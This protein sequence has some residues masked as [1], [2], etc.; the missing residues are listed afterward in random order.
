LKVTI[1]AHDNADNPSSGPR[2]WLTRLV[3]DLLKNS[4]EVNVLVYYW[5]EIKKCPLVT[6][7]KQQGVSTD[8]L[9]Y[10]EF[11]FIEDQVKWTLKC[12]NRF[13]P[14][15]FIPNHPL[16]ALYSVKWCNEVRI[17]SIAVLHSNDKYYRYVL[18]MFLSNHPEFT[19]SAVVCVSDFLKDM[20][21]KYGVKDFR[22]ER[23]SCGSPVP[24]DVAKAPSSELKLLY[25]GRLVEEQKR[26]LSIVEAF[27]ECSLRFHGLQASMYGQGPHRD[28]IADIIRSRGCQNKV[29]IPD[30]V[31][32]SDI[33]NV[34]QQHHVFVLLS[35]FEGLPISLLEAMACGLVPVCLAEESG[36]NEVVKHNINGLIVKDRWD[37][38][39]LAI[40]RLQNEKGLW[41]RLSNKARQTVEQKYSI[42]VENGR[43]LELIRKCGSFSSAG[44]K[45]RVPNIVRLPNPLTKCF[46]VRKTSLAIQASHNLHSFWIKLWSYISSRAIFRTLAKK[47]GL[48]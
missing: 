21:E 30:P 9:C 14:D 7:L 19:P 42:E 41:E 45:V 16:P 5:G 2:V 36:I 46:E 31:L 35:D 8:C 20:V 6:T 47:I 22:I 43:W 34:M 11:Q 12:L 26:I 1:C 29:F 24:K 10:D 39:F 27:C 15:V 3:P 23:I 13:K 17:P 37:D 32:P 25:A 48:M 40:E 4:I 38:F 33:Q 44:S 18:E 28:H